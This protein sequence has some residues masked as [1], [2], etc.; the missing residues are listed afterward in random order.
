V[1]FDVVAALAP[2]GEFLRKVEAT[3]WLTT[4]FGAGVAQGTLH[5]VEV[6]PL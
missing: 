1:D 3:A 6:V 4:S 2:P 5:L